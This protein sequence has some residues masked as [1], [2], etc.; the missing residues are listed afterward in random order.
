M[1]LTPV[2]ANGWSPALT[3]NE[4]FKNNNNSRR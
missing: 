2:D 4:V 3:V 1:E